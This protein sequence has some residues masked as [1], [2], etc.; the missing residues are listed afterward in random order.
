MSFEYETDIAWQLPVPSMHPIAANQLN[1]GQESAFGR[2][3][4]LAGSWLHWL[5]LTKSGRRS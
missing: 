4:P 1:S 5:V 2:K 3:W